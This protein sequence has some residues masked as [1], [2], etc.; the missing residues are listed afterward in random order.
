MGSPPD[1]AKYAALIE[2]LSEIERRASSLE[3]DPLTWSYEALSSVIAFLIADAQIVEREATRPLGRLRFALHDR[4]Q[5][6]E[7]NLF[8]ETPDRKGAK[9]APSYTSAVVLRA[10]VNSA[11]LSLRQGGLSKEEASRWLADELKKSRINQPNGRAVD[12]RT[13]VRWHAELGGKSLTGSDWFLREFLQGGLPA[14]QNAGYQD[15]QP[16]SP[17]DAPT[18]KAAAKGLVKL[19][20][21]AG[22]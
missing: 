2:Q 3:L 9:G 16:S 1:A 13:I 14:L 20:R 22:F 12:A 10:L 11:F 21:A 6:A 17:L 8:F 15:S 7:S 5:G 19:L 18:A 4:M